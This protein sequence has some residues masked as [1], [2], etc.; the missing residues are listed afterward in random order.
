MTTVYLRVW[1]LTEAFSQELSRDRIEL[2]GVYPRSVFCITHPRH[3][4]IILLFWRKNMN[5]CQ[6]KVIVHEKYNYSLYIGW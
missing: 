5:L 4:P 6:V 2:F 3:L 1:V